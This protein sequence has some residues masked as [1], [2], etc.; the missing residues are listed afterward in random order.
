[1]NMVTNMTDTEKIN[2]FIKEYTSGKSLAKINSEYNFSYRYMQRILKQY[3]IPNNYTGRFDQ[4][5]DI[6]EDHAEIY[7]RYKDGYIKALIDLDDVDK[8]KDFGIWSLSS[9]GYITNCKTGIYLHRFV[10]DCPDGIEVDHIYHNLLDNRKSQLRFATSSEQKMNTHKRT[11]NSSGHRGVYWDI[12]REKWHVTVKAGDKRITKRFD[13]YNEA[14]I[15][16]DELINS[17][18]GEYQFKGDDII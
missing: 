5:Y 4:K 1:M 13:D 16:A 15:Y 10:M 6:F 17:M 7:I 12:N 11:D 2:I 8:C 3:N 9:N 18:H 14:C